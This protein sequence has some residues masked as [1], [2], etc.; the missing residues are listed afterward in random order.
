MIFF[1]FRYFRYPTTR[2]AIRVGGY[3]FALIYGDRVLLRTFEYGL[4]FVAVNTT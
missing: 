3:T 4:H 2:A 1:F